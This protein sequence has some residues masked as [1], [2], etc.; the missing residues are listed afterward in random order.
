M[1]PRVCTCVVWYTGSDRKIKEFEEAAGAG[2]QVTKEVD[3]GVPVSQLALLNSVKAMIAATDGGNIRTYKYPLTGELDPI[4]LHIFQSTTV[5][6]SIAADHDSFA[7][8]VMN[9]LLAQHLFCAV[10]LSKNSIVCDLV[11]QRIQDMQ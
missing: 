2:T 11:T 6:R 4:F 1:Y 5:P 9:F 10:M 8:V 3:A 7:A